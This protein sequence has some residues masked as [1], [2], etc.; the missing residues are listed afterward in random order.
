VIEQLLQ[1]FSRYQDAAILISLLASILVAVLGL[2]PS[3]FITAANIYFFGFWPGTLISF[4]GEAIGAIIAFL[5]Y[6]H[7]FKKMTH[8]SLV[9]YPKIMRLITSK[10]KDAFILVLALR[11]IPFV[12]SGLVT[13]AAAIGEV[14]SF[15]F[16]VASSL[17]KVP[18]LM[19]EAYSVA[20]IVEFNWKGK[21]ILTVLA[22][23][24]LIWL[25]RTQKKKERS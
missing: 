2:V 18:A 22:G 11:L 6:R 4:A 19:I 17:G 24:L 20:Q 23:V 9:K 7:G 21:F 3:V 15:V 5:L 10:G 12:P 16:F 8:N 14:S 13:F 25:I 1:I